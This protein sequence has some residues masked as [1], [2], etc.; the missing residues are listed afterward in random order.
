MKACK[1][2]KAKLIFVT[3]TLDERNWQLHDPVDG[4]R[5][6]PLHLLRHLRKFHAFVITT[7]DEGV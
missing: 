2:V 4:T 6:R 1:D 3:E 5:I 7:L